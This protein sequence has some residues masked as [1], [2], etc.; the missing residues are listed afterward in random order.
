[1][2]AFVDACRREWRRLGVD[3]AIANEMAADLSADLDEAAAEG[4]STEDVVGNGIFDP[5]AFAAAWAEA[6]GVVGS[7]ASPPHRSRPSLRPIVFAGVAGVAV[8]I[9]ALVLAVAAVGFHSSSRAA[10]G[11]APNV[12]FGPHGAAALRVFGFPGPFADH[13]ELVARGVVVVAAALL[14]IGVLA[15]VL[16]IVYSSPW[17]RSSRQTPVR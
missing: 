6:R 10:P 2:N 5:Q 8:V 12:R 13:T 14:M 7:P 17:N 16:A 15:V 3:D 9:A 11:Q 1:V 4:A